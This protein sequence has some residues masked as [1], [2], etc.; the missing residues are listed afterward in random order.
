MKYRALSL[1]WAFVAAVAIVACSESDS[2][3]NSSVGG[4]TSATGGSSSTSTGGSSSTTTS[5]AAGKGNAVVCKTGTDIKASSGTA[6]AACNAFCVAEDPC[7][8]DTT[9]AA[10]KE[11][12]S[13]S[14]QDTGPAGCPEASKKLWDC[15]NSQTDLCST[16][17]CCKSFQEA[18][19][20]ACNP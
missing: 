7:D 19:T 15:L 10:C 20:A 8:P 18:V 13:C 11:Y 9:V 4:S 3:S 1:V 5:S 14:I 12:R 6:E 2:N 17:S 16:E